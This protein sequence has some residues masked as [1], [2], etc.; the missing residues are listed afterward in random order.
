MLEPLFAVPMVLVA[1]LWAGSLL[2]CVL[3]PGRRVRYVPKLLWLLFMFSAPLIGLLAWAYLGK[4]PEP[5][6]TPEDAVKGPQNAAKGPAHRAG[7]FV[8]KR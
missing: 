7:P 1:L 3:T 8:H 5:R 6:E 2:D 4:L